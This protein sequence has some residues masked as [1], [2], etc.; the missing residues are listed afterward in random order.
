[1]DERK[2]AFMID[3][4][5]SVSII[6]TTNSAKMLKRPQ[7]NEK[8]RNNNGEPTAVRKDTPCPWRTKQRTKQTKI[9]CK[10]RQNT[11]TRHLISLDNNI[12]SSTIK[13]WLVSHATQQFETL[14]ICQKLLSGH[15]NIPRTQSG[16]SRQRPLQ[17]KH[18]KNQRLC[19]QCKKS[20]RQSR[21]CGSSPNPR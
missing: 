13:A 14:N 15:K 6:I 11:P 4:T 8:E 20:N 1:M 19:R 18:I 12:S 7:K 17:K 2:F 21:L 9:Q 3:L 10:N 5:F 16:F